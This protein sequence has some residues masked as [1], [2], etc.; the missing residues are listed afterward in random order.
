MSDFV[1]DLAQIGARQVILKGY[2]TGY[3]PIPAF[4][5]KRLARAPHFQIKHGLR[6]SV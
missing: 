6:P 2:E 1:Y 5:V 4:R 3:L